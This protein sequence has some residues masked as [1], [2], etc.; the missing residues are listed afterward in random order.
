MYN[1]VILITLAAPIPLS[2]NVDTISTNSEFRPL[3]VSYAYVPKNNGQQTELSAQ[4]DVAIC[5]KSLFGG[6]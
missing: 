4:N 3:I 2:S 1:A 5:S 6:L